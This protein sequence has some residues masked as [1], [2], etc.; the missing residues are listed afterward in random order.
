VSA[1]DV[2]ARYAFQP[3]EEAHFDEVL[4]IERLSYSNPWVVDAFRHEVEQNA[5]SRPRVATTLDEPHTV[6]G[7][8]VSWL[9]V[10]EVQ[11]QNVAVHPRHRGR[12]LARHLL[13]RAL[14]EGL[15]AGARSAQLEVRS[16]NAIAL[17][18]YA[19][20]G[21]RVVGERRGYYSRPQEDAV[22]LHKE[23]L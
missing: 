2:L 18:L 14:Q 13:S 16:G 23:L 9:V 8:C 4:E 12:G 10:D 6:A 21:F 7:Y 1:L 19:S 15:D 20:L 5:L 3:M 17:K 11:I 22:L